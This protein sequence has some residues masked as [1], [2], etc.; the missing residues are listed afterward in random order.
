MLT[1]P[2]ALD[3]LGLALG[4]HGHK[5]TDRE[6]QLYETAVAMASG[7][8]TATDSAASGRY[9]LQKPSLERP[10]VSARS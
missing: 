6:R 2:S 1:I 5:W 4:G 10:L 8:C 9:P 7:G 3:S